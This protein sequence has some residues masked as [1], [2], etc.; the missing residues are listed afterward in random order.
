MTTY[1]AANLRRCVLVTPNLKVSLH[2]NFVVTCSSPTNC[3]MS[4]CALRGAL[5]IGLLATVVQNN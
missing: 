2:R 5:R 3:G 4:R 1:C